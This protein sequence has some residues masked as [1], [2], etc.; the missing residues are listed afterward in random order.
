MPKKCAKIYQQYPVLVRHANLQKLCK[1]YI[2]KQK[3]PIFMHDICK[4]MVFNI[5]NTQANQLADLFL[6]RRTL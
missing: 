1:A 5:P 6:L 3:N 2:L 4:K